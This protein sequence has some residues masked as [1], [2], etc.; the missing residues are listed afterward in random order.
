[1]VEYT[2]KPI[3]RQRSPAMVI[4]QH[5]LRF[6]EVSHFMTASSS[7]PVHRGVSVCC[8]RGGV[9]GCGLYLCQ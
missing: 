4:S 2:F 6:N 1:M 9:S 8:K 5:L 3:G 7:S